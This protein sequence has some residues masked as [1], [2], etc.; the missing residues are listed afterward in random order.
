M[1]RAPTPM[2]Q[3]VDLRKTYTLGGSSIHALDGVTMR[4][5]A[6]EFVAV[7]GS[8]GSGKST[9]M[10]MLG[11]L[12]Q[13]DSG[14]V[15]INGQNVGTLSSRELASYRGETLGFVFQQ[16]QLM[17]RR[18]ALQN[19]MMPLQYRR[20]RLPDGE[21]RASKALA[22]VGLGDRGH[23]KPKEL[24]GGQQQRVAIARALVGSP[25]LLLADEPTGALDSKTSAE[26]M[27]L[28]VR[29]NREDGLT[30]VLITHDLEVA[31]YAARIITM[32]DGRIISDVANDR[33]A[34]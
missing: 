14:D 25:A 29:L 24:S 22:A 6:G 12:D 30:I 18:S 4:V 28:L 26:I 21:D 31:D 11:G 19:V 32:S 13:P 34:A 20:P 3:T 27:D 2:I 17:S 7:I 15:I 8:S 33:E 1:S 5:A 10:N 23:H 9:L 16:F